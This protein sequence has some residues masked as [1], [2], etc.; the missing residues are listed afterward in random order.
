MKNKIFVLLVGMLVIIGLSIYLFFAKSFT[1]TKLAIEI[2]GTKLEVET[3]KI[4][5]SVDQLFK[6]DPKE[7]Y[8]DSLRGFFFKKTQN[9]HW[10]EPVAVK[11]NE[12][13]INE[14]D[15]QYDSYM[16]VQEKKEQD[17]QAVAV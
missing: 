9:G 3:S 17:A 1:S 4:S 5:A 13:I 10:S 6:L 7:F 15:E 11:D 8:I 14:K 12:A 2:K 16:T